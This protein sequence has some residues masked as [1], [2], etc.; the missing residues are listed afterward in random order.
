MWIAFVP[1]ETVILGVYYALVTSNES[2]DVVC[3]VICVPQ[4]FGAGLPLQDAIIYSI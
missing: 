2:I 1:I 3:C 4:F